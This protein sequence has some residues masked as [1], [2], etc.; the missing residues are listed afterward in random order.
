M[1]VTTAYERIMLAHVQENAGLRQMEFGM[2]AGRP[3]R[4]WRRIQRGNAVTE[5]TVR[6]SKTMAVGE[7]IRLRSVL[8]TLYVKVRNRFV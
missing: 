5:R 3:R 6:Q 4:V 8:I 2:R 7:R 1:H